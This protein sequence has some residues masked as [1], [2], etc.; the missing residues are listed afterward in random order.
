MND[1]QNNIVQSVYYPDAKNNCWEREKIYLI[2]KATF[3]V[4]LKPL[5]HFYLAAREKK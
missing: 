4:D 3:V 2:I 1:S 5:A